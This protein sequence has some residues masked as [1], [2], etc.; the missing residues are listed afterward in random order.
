MPEVSTSGQRPPVQM[1]EVSGQRPPVQ[2]P[3]VRG[4]STKVQGHEGSKPHSFKASEEIPQSLR[5]GHGPD[6][7]PGEAAEAPPASEPFRFWP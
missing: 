7:P 6:P 3:E 1:P 4:Q 2:T 5:G